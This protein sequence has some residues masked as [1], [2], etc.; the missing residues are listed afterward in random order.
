MLVT[1]Q[2]EPSFVGSNVIDFQYTFSR[3]LLV[4]E[5]SSNSNL[6]LVRVIFCD[7][8]MV[9]ILDFG[10]FKKDHLASERALLRC[11]LRSFGRG[12]SCGNIIGFGISKR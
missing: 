5:E 9:G 4:R 2:A 10:A 3:M 6:S 1:R 8:I 7:S 11:S 12:I